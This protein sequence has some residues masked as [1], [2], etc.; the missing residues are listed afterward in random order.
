M[1]DA[2]TSVLTREKSSSLSELFSVE[3]KFTIDT[4]NKSF[5]T[6]IKPKFLQKPGIKKQTFN[7]E[8][9]LIS[10][11]TGCYIYGISLD[12]EACGEHDRW[13]D[14]IV[15]TEHLFIRN[16]YTEDDLEQMENV[17]NTCNYYASFEKFIELVPIV[18]RLTLMKC[19]YILV[20]LRMP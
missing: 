4:L 12:T 11:K 5:S 17:K 18:E 2:A 6:I 7:K 9:L 14:F 13:F 8:N 10:S 19:M 20:K 15:E 1:K 3:L 16:I